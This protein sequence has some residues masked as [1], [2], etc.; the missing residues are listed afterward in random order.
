MALR[1]RFSHL[2]GAGDQLKV[3]QAHKITKAFHLT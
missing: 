1:L 2:T 3:G